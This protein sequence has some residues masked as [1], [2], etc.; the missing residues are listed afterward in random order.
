MRGG[1]QEAFHTVG[2]GLRKHFRSQIVKTL[3]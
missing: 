1:K 3:A 2:E